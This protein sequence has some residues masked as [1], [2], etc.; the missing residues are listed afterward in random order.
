ML[1][2]LGLLFGL[3]AGGG[4]LAGAAAPPA[5]PPAPAVTVTFAAGLAARFADRYGDAEAD[6]LRAIAT[7][8]M[9]RAI[10]R[11][12]PSTAA[13][14]TVSVVL[15]DAV[16][17][18]PTRAE[19]LTNPALDPLRSR[20]LGGARLTAE[21]RDATGQVLARVARDHYAP[22]FDVA[23]P[24]GD[25]WADARVAIDGAAARLARALRAAQ[26]KPR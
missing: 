14:L 5:T 20:S 15:E 24:A 2:R 17:S 12:A 1:I 26:A 8:A 25:A 11:A 21:V 9:V 6:T 22:D 16:A 19:V 23:S 3:L 13:S 10:R 18:H 7:E 4:A